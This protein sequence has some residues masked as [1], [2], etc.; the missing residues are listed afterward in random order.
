MPRLF[1]SSIVGRAFGA[2]VLMLLVS[3]G[4]KPEEAAPKKTAA[5]PEAAFA[6]T[7]PSGGATVL[8][9][10]ATAKSGDD[11]V[12]VGRIGGERRSFADLA[13]SFTIVDPSLPAC[14]EAGVPDACETPWDYCCEDKSKLRAAS[15]TIEFR[16]A[17]GPLKGSAEGVRGLAHMKTVVVKGK[18]ERDAA[19][20]LVVAAE[21][22]FV[23]P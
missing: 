14:G 2:S 5:I 8:E 1:R 3:C 17:K 23:R 13:A 11:V 19:G 22:I 15:A 7:E 18:A 20:N 12:V 6:T 16:D 9:A 10:K 4:S 21:S